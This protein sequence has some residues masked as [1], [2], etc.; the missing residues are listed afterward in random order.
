MSE[1]TVID[2]IRSMGVEATSELTWSV[3][4][5]VREMWRAEHG[6][7]PEK[8]LR[9]KTGGPGSHCFA[10]YPAHW[11][12]RIVAVVQQHVHFA[13]RQIRLL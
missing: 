6:E 8:G 12:E 2:V 3:G 7:L 1:I 11:R 4:A 13:E 9:P 10:V 5:Q